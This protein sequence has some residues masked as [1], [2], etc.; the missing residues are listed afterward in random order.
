[1]PSSPGME[2]IRRRDCA[3]KPR[4]CKLRL[5]GYL[6][7][8]RGGPGSSTTANRCEQFAP[9]SRKAARWRC[10]KN[11]RS[12]LFPWRPF[13]ANDTTDAKRE[14]SSG[15]L[16]TSRQAAPMEAVGTTCV[17]GS[18]PQRAPS[19][20]L[21]ASGR[22][23]GRPP[24]HKSPAGSR[25]ADQVMRDLGSP[26]LPEFDPSRGRGSLARRDPMPRRRHRRLVRGHSSV[27]VPAL[28][29]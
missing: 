21:P 1:M 15:A 24:V 19:E 4:G 3:S 11:S 7:V 27:S 10:T 5:R 28:E 6:H 20:G 14:K 9:R 13:F 18:G 25:H 16:A 26:R 8:V 12:D 22:R 2:Q 29:T 23:E 17:C